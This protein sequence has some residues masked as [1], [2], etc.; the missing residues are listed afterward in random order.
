[1]AENT[2]RGHDSSMI[3]LL[4][5]FPMLVTRRASVAETWQ[6]ASWLYP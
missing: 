4:S 2:K 5:N 6:Q 3:F 1:M